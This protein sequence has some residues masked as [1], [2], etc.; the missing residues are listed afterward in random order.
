M[1][2]HR[3]KLLL[4]FLFAAA[5]ISAV[6]YGFDRL[7]LTEGVPRFDVLLLTDVLTGI[8][9]GALFLQFK[10]RSMEKQKLLED[11]LQKIADMNHH[12]R[13][14]LQVVSYYGYLSKDSEATKLIDESIRRIEW[15]LREVLP[16]GWDL[17][18]VSPQNGEEQS[19]RM[20]A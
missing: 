9:A 12:V 18:G 5:F 4:G 16:R 15:T 1:S 11:R 14:A 17:D 2:G 10:I 3:T 6:G 7:L 13:N 20:S 8:V 19:P